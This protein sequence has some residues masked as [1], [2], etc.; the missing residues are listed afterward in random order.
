[1]AAAK[2]RD[3]G[4]AGADVALQQA[5]HALRLRQIGD[6]IVDRALLRR[7]QRVGQGGDDALAQ[8]AL[9]G[10]AMAGQLPHMRAQQGERELAGEQFV[11]G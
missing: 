11:V 7:R 8:A 5:Q 2:Q 6:D 9:G 10:A 3:D 4:L 1:M